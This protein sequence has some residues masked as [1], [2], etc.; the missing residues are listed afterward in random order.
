MGELACTR[1]EK[2]VKAVASWMKE[3]AGDRGKQIGGSVV[4][5]WMREVAGTRIEQIE[6]LVAN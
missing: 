5:G 4:T 3:V 1:G 6:E 2:L